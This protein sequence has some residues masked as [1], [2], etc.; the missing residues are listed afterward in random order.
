MQDVATLG[1]ALRVS[2]LYKI[3]VNNLAD[4]DLVAGLPALGLDALLAHFYS[5]HEIT[6]PL[7]K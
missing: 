7:N 5:C 3:I 6:S 4:G 1:L 2:Y